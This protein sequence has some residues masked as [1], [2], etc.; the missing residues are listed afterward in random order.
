MTFEMYAIYPLQCAVEILC[1]LFGEFI[2][3]VMSIS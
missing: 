3:N 1:M 2:E